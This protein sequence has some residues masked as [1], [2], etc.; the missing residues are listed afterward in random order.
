MAITDVAVD[1][2]SYTYPCCPSEPWPVALFTVTMRREPWAYFSMVLMPGIAIT[3]LSFFVFLADTGSADALGYG[4]GVIVV[5]L[6]SNFILVGMLPV[7]GEPQSC[8]AVARALTH[9]VLRA[10]ALLQLL[11]YSVQC[12]LSD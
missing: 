8:R 2:R 11:S 5:N 9:V 3:A 7:C 12:A 4:I 6:L 1:L 10:V